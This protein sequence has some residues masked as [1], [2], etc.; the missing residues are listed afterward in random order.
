MI[1]AKR[2]AGFSGAV[3]KLGRQLIWWLVLVTALTPRDLGRAAVRQP[4]AAA[5][6]RDE[7]R[8]GRWCLSP[9]RPALSGDPARQR[10]QARI[11]ARRAAESRTCSGSAMARS[12]WA[13]S[14]AAPD[15]WRSTPSAAPESTP[16][17]SLAT[18]AFEPVWIFTHT[19]DLSE[20]PQPLAGKTRRRRRSGQRQLPAL[21]AAAVD[22]WRPGRQPA[23]HAATLRE[24]RRHGGRGDARNATRSMQPSSSPPR[25]TGG[26]AGSCP[27]A[28]MPPRLAGPCRGPR[29]PLPVLPAGEPEAW[30]GRSATRPAA[31]GHHRC[32][33]PPPTSWCATNCIRALAYL[34]LEAARQVHEQP[35]THQPTR[36]VSEPER[37]PNSR[38]PTEAERYFKNG[39]PF[40]QSYSAVLGGGPCSAPRPAARSAGCDPA[41]YG[42]GGAEVRRM[43][44]RSAPLSTRTA[45]LKRHERV[46]ASHR[47]DDAERRE[48]RAHLDRDREGDRPGGFPLDLSDRVYTLRQHIDYVRAR[49]DKQDELPRA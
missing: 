7:H 18:V 23:A 29:A 42:A 20:G 32:W 37:R 12:P 25:G 40:L 49:L 8:S 33:R 17:R 35:S 45:E 14:R 16:L 46:V 6:H 26:A 24:R 28:S 19:L 34:L 27:T 1:D 9:L 4:G 13:L 10:R 39:R 15:C 47:L 48:A 44:S 43:A 2:R 30:L 3:R 41:A 22:L 21:P 36:R 5:R 31:A 11:C 38:C